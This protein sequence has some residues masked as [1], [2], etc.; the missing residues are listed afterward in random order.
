MT[1]STSC[2]KKIVKVVFRIK[3][4]MVL[5]TIRIS[6]RSSVESDETFHIKGVRRSNSIRLKRVGIDVINCYDKN[7]M[8]LGNIYIICLV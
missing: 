4:V 2:E 5:F 3:V 8:A 7:G 6:I 1:A